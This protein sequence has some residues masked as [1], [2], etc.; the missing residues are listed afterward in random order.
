MASVTNGVPW[1]TKRVRLENI[2]IWST[3]EMVHVFKE[4]QVVRRLERLVKQRQSVPL[5]MS[6]LYPWEVHQELALR[7]AMQNTH[8]QKDKDVPNLKVPHQAPEPV[9]NNK[10]SYHLFI[11]VNKVQWLLEH[12]TKEAFS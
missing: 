11:A 2:A 4:Q 7:F 1:I 3:R 10:K 8:V 5:G 12:I 6:V 9:Q